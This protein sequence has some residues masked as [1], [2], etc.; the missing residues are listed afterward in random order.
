MFNGGRISTL[1]KNRTYRNSF[2]N[3]IQ[4][5]YLAIPSFSVKTIAFVQNWNLDVILRLRTNFFRLEKENL[6]R[7]FCKKLMFW[8]EN[9]DCVKN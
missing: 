2:D 9:D 3:E 4:I 6:I 5:Q 1:I 8:L 7:C